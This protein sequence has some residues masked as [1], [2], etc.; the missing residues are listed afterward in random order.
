MRDLAGWSKIIVSILAF[1]W[2]VF[3]VYT[4]LTVSLHPILQGSISLS[5]G[6][7]I[8][9]LAYPFSAKSEIYRSEKKH[10]L[11]PLVFGTTRMPSLLDFLFIAI[12]VG[13]CLYI[14]IEWEI[15]V[16]S[17]GYYDTY[18]L[19]IGLFLIVGLL[20]GTRRS[21]GLS[22]PILM[23][24]FIGYAMYGHH[25]P[26]MFGHAGF[27]GE[28]ILYQLFLMQE[29]IWGLLTDMT[30]RLIALFVLFGPVLFATGVG[31][32]FM[33]IAMISG[34]RVRGGAGHVAVVGSS[35]FGMLSGSSVA[36]V[37]TTGSFTIPTMKKLRFPPAMAGAVEA[38]AS[39]G[40]QIMPPIMGAGCFIMAEFLNVPYV[41]VMIA[42]II[43]GVLYFIGVSA[44]IWVEAGRYGLG[45]LPASM[46]PKFK[47]AFG[48][49]QLITFVAPVGLLM[50]MLFIHYP[51]QQAAAWALMVCMINFLLIGGPLNPASMWE[52][53]KIIWV[54]GYFRAVITALAWLMVMMSC[55]QMAVT[56]ISMTGFGVKVSAGIMGLAGTHIMLALFA[57]ML[58]AMLLG[59]GMTT[60]AAYVIAAAVLVP[61]MENLGLPA[62]ASHLFIF[63]FAIKSGLTPPVCITV[64][65]A[66]A[67]AGSHWLRTAWYSI[68]LGIGGYILPFYFILM[69]EYLMQ[70]SPLMIAYV[71]ASGIAAMFAIEAGLMGFFNKPATILERSLYMIAGL[72][73]LAPIGYSLLG[74]VIW[75][76]AYLLER[77][78]IRLPGDT[79]PAI[80][81]HYYKGDPA[82]PRIASY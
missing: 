23:L 7:A 80:D 46:M 74:Y 28:E 41:T 36:N 45:K 44:G 5:F 48:I 11:K 25:I 13:P 71:V 57:T 38:S 1:V 17:P 21:L 19:V 52:R 29:G 58:I 73:I 62:L 40:G 2:C 3:L 15:I 9:F 59:M 35:F 66:A 6:L 12:S 16:R 61:A 78:D 33:D 70:G 47:E 31:K 72:M 18:Q 39:S 42:G 14:M 26:G 50:F 56:L 68:R 54:D 60:T 79:R 20:E 76:G 55:V 10:I 4:A 82:D 77:Y 24:C 67:I 69:P 8:V 63:Y 32:T 51:A 81:K 27:E 64:F 34:G 65:T 49:R 43:P 22:I 30:A 37:A 53:I 75:I